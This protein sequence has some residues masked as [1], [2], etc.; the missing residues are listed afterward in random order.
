MALPVKL[1]LSLIAA[2]PVLSTD[3]FAHR[4]DILLFLAPNS[5]SNLKLEL[6]EE[7]ERQ[8]EPK[9]GVVLEDKDS[10]GISI[11]CFVILSSSV[12]KYWP[13]VPCFGYTV[14]ESWSDWY[15]GVM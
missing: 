4:T 14:L 6:D 10:I 3:A 8:Q 15:F 1:F 13:Q 12:E 2:S 9:Y 5:Q 11:A 7:E